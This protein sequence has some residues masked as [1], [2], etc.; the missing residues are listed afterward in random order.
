MMSKSKAKRTRQGRCKLTLKDGQFVDSHL[1]PKALTKA[2]GLG[3]GLIQ[4]GNGRTKQ[5]RSSWYDPNLV[6]KEGEDILG[7]YDN[8]AIRELRKYNLVWSGWG[9]SDNLVDN[10][11]LGGFCGI[12]RLDGGDWKKLRLF[13]LSILWRA[14]ATDLE[15]FAEID[16]PEGHIEQLR[17][18]IINKDYSHLGFYPIT[19]TQIS[20]RGRNHNHA[21]FASVL[22][23][24]HLDRPGEVLETPIFRFYMDGLIIH[25]SRLPEE[26][27]NE[28][29]LGPL[30]V[31][32]DEKALVVATV[33]WES[34]NQMLNGVITHTEALLGR[35]LWELDR[36]PFW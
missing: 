33:P 11:D 14:A 12:R 2:D 32:A 7:V 27:N 30:W 16:L 1:L 35:P 34:S 13:F 25:F 5:Y 19:L 24:P 4:I 15:E 36:G 28:L 29:D 17:L 18:M 26:R 22:K 20:T 3:P 6:I 21:P 10:L 9:S 23:V 31:G 8:W